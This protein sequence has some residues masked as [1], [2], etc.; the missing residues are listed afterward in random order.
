MIMWQGKPTKLSALHIYTMFDAQDEAEEGSPIPLTPEI[1]KQCGFRSNHK[2]PF[3]IERFCV[4]TLGS[5]YLFEWSKKDDQFGTP[6]TN[7]KYL[8][9]LQNLFY[10]LHGEELPVNV[11]KLVK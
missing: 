1:F 11:K 6:A 9:E 5:G 7:F 3:S 4:Y 10:A 8:H 2:V